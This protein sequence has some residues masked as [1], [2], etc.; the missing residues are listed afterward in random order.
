MA[1]ASMPSA[2]GPPPRRAFWRRGETDPDR[3]PNEIE[4]V[5][6]E[7]YAKPSEIADA[8]AFRQHPVRLHQRPGA[9]G[10]WRPD[11]VRRLNSSLSRKLKMSKS[12]DTTSQEAAQPRA[13]STIPTIPDMTA[14]YLERYLNYGLT[15]EELQSGKPII[16][17][18]QTGSDLSPCN[19]HHIELAKR[20]REGIREAGGIAMEFPVH[21]D[22]GNR[23]APHRRAGPQ[24]G[25]YGPGG[26]ALRLSAGRRGADHRLRQDHARLP[27]GGGHRRTFP[28]SLCRSARC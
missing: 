7:R 25:L 22:P 18:A 21:P 19:R 11:A 23:Q 24:P 4:G 16:G 14:L 3:M 17:I 12:A 20:V 5:S 9:A 26:T 1:C 28:P 10:G 8:V 2:P 6:L 27:D 13:G 15:R